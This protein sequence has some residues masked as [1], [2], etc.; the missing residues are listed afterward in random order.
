MPKKTY[1]LIINEQIKE[2]SSCSSCRNIKL[3]QPCIM[4]LQLHFPQW[5]YIQFMFMLNIDSERIGNN[6]QIH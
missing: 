5:E 2:E 3:I 6:L 1:T 4:I